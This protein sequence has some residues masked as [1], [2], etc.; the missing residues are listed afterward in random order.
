[1]ELSDIKVGELARENFAIIQFFIKHN[2]DFFCKGTK[3]LREALDESGAEKEKFLE[4]LE[5][6][7]SHEVQRYAVDID[8]WPLDL[9]AD[10][11]QKTHHRHTEEVLLKIKDLVKEILANDPEEA[12]IIR[13]FNV[14]FEFLSGELAKHMKKEE[15][16]LF[17][18]IKKPGG[19]SA[20]DPTPIFGSVD[21][22]VGNMIGEH[23][24]QYEALRKIRKILNGYA[25]REGKD[26]YNKLI[27]QMEGLDKDLA[28]HLHLENN[29]LFPKAVQLVKT[30][31]KI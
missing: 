29:I 23:D 4:E 19:K 16:M 2:I 11:I 20:Q 27:R 8:S 17:P 5:D 14:T 1:M 28:L 9:L 24:M 30:Q 18:A 25:P 13:E 26:V 3:S 10:Y 12:G 31:V 7:R 6:I 22:L 21:K 15:L